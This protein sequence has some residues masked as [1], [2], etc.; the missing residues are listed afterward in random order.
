LT[1]FSEKRNAAD[2]DA[3]ER[4]IAQKEDEMEEEFCYR[5]FEFARYGAKC[6]GPVLQQSLQGDGLTKVLSLFV[7]CS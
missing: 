3:D 4:V 5:L 6:F 1:V 7:R 2:Y